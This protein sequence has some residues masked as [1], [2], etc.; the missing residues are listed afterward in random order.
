VDEERGECIG[1]KYSYKESSVIGVRLHNGV[2][3]N[4][5]VTKRCMHESVHHFTN[6]AYN[7]FFM[8]NAL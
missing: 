2:F 3:C 5:R 6:L 8:S 7:Y 1:R 4:Y